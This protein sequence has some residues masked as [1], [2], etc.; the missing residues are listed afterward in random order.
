MRRL[1]LGVPSLSLMFCLVGRGSMRCPTTRFLLPHFRLTLRSRS[2]LGPGPWGLS[3]DGMDC[4]C[5]PES[6]GCDLFVPLADVRNSC[7]AEARRLP[8]IRPHLIQRGSVVSVC[9]DVSAGPFRCC[10]LHFFALQV[11]G[12]PS[13]P[14]LRPCS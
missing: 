6:A 3:G 11:Q 1:W 9:G 2:S 12:E 10:W 13:V 14:H 5:L 8:V 7:Y 4:A